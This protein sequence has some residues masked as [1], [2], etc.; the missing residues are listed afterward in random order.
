MSRR[1]RILERQRSLL[2]FLGFVDRQFSCVHTLR[3]LALERGLVRQSHVFVV[4]VVIPSH[5]IS[6]TSQHQPTISLEIPATH[7]VAT[8]SESYV[9]IVDFFRPVK[10]STCE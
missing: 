6:M 10:S 9:S 3:Q 8:Q 7:P 2:D 1:R 4:T 5:I